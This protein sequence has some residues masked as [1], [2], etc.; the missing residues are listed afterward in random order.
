[1]THLLYAEINVI[2][3]VLLLL[4]LGN[5]NKNSHKNITMDQLIFNLC[6]ISNLF[7]FIF[8]MGM[9]LLNGLAGTGFLVFNYLTTVL[10]YISNP[11]ICFLWLLYSDFK[12]NESREGL[13]RR[14]RFYVIPFVINAILSI[15]SIFTGW[16]FM[17]DD[18]NNYS[19]GPYFF[20][21]AIAS[22]FYLTYAIFISLRD[23]RKNGWEENK[24][25]NSYLVIFPILIVLVSLIQIRFFGLSII[26][27]TAMLAFASMY[28]NIQNGEISTDHLTGLSNRRRLEEYLQ[29]R[30]KRQGKEHQLL[31]TIMMDLDDFKTINDK[32]GHAA[33]DDALV[34]MSEIL[35]KVCKNGDDFI[36]RMGGDEF[37]I[38][39]ERLEIEEVKQI[40]EE[41]SIR[42]NWYNKRTVEGYYIKPSMGF[43]VFQKEDS[44]DSFLANADQEMYRNKQ[45]RKVENI[46][47]E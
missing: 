8:D 18:K 30:I 13:L 43:S 16:L 28:I 44:I 5:M 7:I 37:I 21:M 10:Y 6:L 3:I 40:M 39:G 33:G 17:I 46:K 12:I 42:V 19:R 32:F 24:N 36:G 11:F 31:F 26:W 4:F 29:R 23:I 20:I 41:I 2:G 14:I 47:K 38:V 34:N 45:K 1:M 9:W 35:Q 22:L 15:V 27:V 25:V